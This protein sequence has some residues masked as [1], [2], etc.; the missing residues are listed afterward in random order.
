MIKRRSLKVSERWGEGIRNHENDKR[1]DT[2]LAEEKFK[3]IYKNLTNEQKKKVNYNDALESSRQ[4]ANKAKSI[5][6]LSET[7]MLI[8]NPNDRRMTIPEFIKSIKT[9]LHPN[10]VFIPNNLIGENV[11]G[12]SVYFNHSEDLEF[13]CGV[14]KNL[15][16]FIEPET[17]FQDINDGLK[18]E[19]KIKSRGYL[20]AVQTIGSWLKNHQVAIRNDNYLN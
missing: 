6:F 19:R 8:K 12:H 7:D 5:K 13:I 1:D 17:E 14:G 9:N 3:E 18:V 10:L 4:I 2:L 15:E 20:A 11:G 16:Q